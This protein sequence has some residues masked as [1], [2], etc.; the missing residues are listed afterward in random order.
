ML[1]IFSGSLKLAHK[2]N[3]LL[4]EENNYRLDFFKDRPKFFNFSENLI[5][6]IKEI[7][8]GSLFNFQIYLVD[9]ELIRDNLDIDFTIGGNFCRYAYIP[10][11]EIWV[12]EYLHPSDISPTIVHEI[13]ESM[14]MGKGLS[15]DSAHNKANI[16]EFKLRKKINSGEIKIDTN[17]KILSCASKVVE[18][19]LHEHKRDI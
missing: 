11:N 16:Y 3:L 13:V 6:N 1:K 12:S 8:L 2:N 14:L 17:S 10:P 18:D 7:K 9:D 5:N 19:F 15:Y 4:K